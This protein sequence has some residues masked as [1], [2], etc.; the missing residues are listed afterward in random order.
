[1]LHVRGDFA[2]LSKNKPAP[3]R[4]AIAFQ[5]K[6]GLILLDQIR[7]L[8]KARLVKRLGAASPKTLATTLRTLTEVF[9]P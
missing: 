3:F 1:L 4:I 7:T 5:D 8:D 6:R 2:I 9:A